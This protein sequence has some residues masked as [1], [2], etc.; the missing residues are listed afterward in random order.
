[1]VY[2]AKV[3]NIETKMWL[4]SGCNGTLDD[5]TTPSHPLWVDFQA[6]IYTKQIQ[7]H[8][9]E[10]EANRLNCSMLQRLVL[11]RQKRGNH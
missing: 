2:Q 5:T 7:T 6:D 4:L 8:M 1:M 9:L 10:K 11:D 3:K